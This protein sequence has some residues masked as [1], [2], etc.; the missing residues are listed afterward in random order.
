M[1]AILRSTDTEV[2]SGSTCAPHGGICKTHVKGT[3]S[4]FNQVR[5]GAAHVSRM[6]KRR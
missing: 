2:K 5:R 6:C 3:A 4:A 1:A